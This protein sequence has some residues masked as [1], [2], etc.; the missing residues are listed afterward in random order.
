MNHCTGKTPKKGAFNTPENH[1]EEIIG[2]TTKQAG[3]VKGEKTP[4]EHQGPGGYYYE[5]LPWNQEILAFLKR[6]GYIFHLVLETSPWIF[7]GFT[8]IAILQGLIPVAQS[9][10]A[11]QILNLLA[12]AFIHGA[13][14]YE[15]YLSRIM[16][17]LILQFA[18][19]I[20]LNVVNTLNNIMDHIAGELVVNHVNMKIMEKAKELDTASFDSPDFY[21]KLE[22]ASRES[23]N[24]PTRIIRALFSVISAVISMISFIVI[25]CAVNP[26]APILIIAVSVP[27]ALVSMHYRRK[28][29]MYI[30]RNSKDRR[31]LTYYKDLLTNKDMAKEI[32]IFRLADFILDRYS[33][34][35][36]KYFKGLKK[37]FFV[38]GA[39]NLGMTMISAAVNC[40]LFFYIAS[41]VA[42]GILQVGHYSL[43][44][45]ALNSISN[46]VNTIINNISS[47]YEGTLFIDNM[48]IFMNEETTIVP[49]LSEHSSPQNVQKH[50]G[51][52]I[53]FQHVYFKYPGQE[54]YTLQDINVTL[55]PGE[56]VT[57]VGLNG[58]GKTTFLKLLIRLYD[59][60]EGR[61]L[62]DDIDIR[63][64]DVNDL[65][66]I[67]GIIFQDFGKYAVDV[68]ENIA[69][70]D[71][72]IP[73]NEERIQK[74]ADFSDAR[75]YIERLPHKFK[76]P[77]T[78]YFEK[79]GVELSIGQWQKLSIAR[80]FYTNADILILDEPTAALDAIAEQEIYN[81]FETLSENKT[82][83][84]VSHRL[85]SATTAD[86][87][88]VLEYGKIVEEG[89]HHDLMEKQGIYYRLFSTQAERYQKK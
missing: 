87:I 44:T 9:Y 45:G 71:I 79:N 7:I 68:E 59:P 20:G 69:F 83:I 38:E 42:K 54:Q 65:Y 88:I 19:I 33:Q 43:Y 8:V 75:D 35:F 39:C 62:L 11:A 41:Q 80:A 60:T 16:S 77:L 15:T 57:I 37:L 30:R 66:S 64:Y 32:K 52:K 2:E 26:A 4:R 27:S 13:A 36:K 3:G 40:Y 53:E 29:F 12:D 23:G 14:A 74:A 50:I 31:Q 22:N 34:I 61:I 25:L 24:S 1:A 82:T 73:I 21:A 58:A 6:L 67:Y 78:H 63:E 28:N 72:T 85:S 55:Q 56:K 89:V 5:I 48:L 51:H 46:G 86:K 17:L 10:V 84:F 70:G 76:T 81:Q 49:K 47:I 18:C